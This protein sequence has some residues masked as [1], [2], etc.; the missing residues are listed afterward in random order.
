MASGRDPAALRGVGD[1]A[2]VAQEARRALHAAVAAARAAGHTWA[3]IGAV[4]GTSR[5]AAFKRF[6]GPRDPRTGGTMT[7]APTADLLAAT[8][9]V[10]ARLDA[11]DYEVL[12]ERMADDVAA[13]LTREVVLDTWARV[14]ADTGNLESCRGTRLEL[15]DGSSVTEGDAVL[16]TVVGHTELVCEAGSWVGRVAWDERRRIAGLLVL[17][18]GADY[19]F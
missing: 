8:E 11:G 3:E 13:V 15:P 4:L 1:A 17:P 9:E 14:V 18:P 19:P 7:G 12:R 16:G 6:G 2:A 10:F 5:Q